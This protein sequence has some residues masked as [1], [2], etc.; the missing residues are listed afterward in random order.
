MSANKPTL[1][2]MYD[3]D[4]ELKLRLT[5]IVLPGSNDKV[6]VELMAPPILNLFPDKTLEPDFLDKV[7]QEFEKERLNFFK[8]HYPER[9]KAI[10]Q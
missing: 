7:F 3:I 4:E 6:L 8:E 10:M 2:C 9:Y 1:S 5:L